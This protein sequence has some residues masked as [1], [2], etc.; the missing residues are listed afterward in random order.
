MYH[1][2]TCFNIY[3]WDFCLPTQ[4]IHQFLTHSFIHGS[5]ALCCALAAFSVS[6]SYTVSK[7]PW[8]GDQPVSRPLPT[9]TTAQTRNKR[10]HP[11]LEWDSNPSLECSSGRR[12]FVPKT[13]AF[14]SH[15]SYNTQRPLPHQAGRCR[16]HN[17]EF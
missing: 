16:G 6:Y 13:G 11:S 14:A 12:Q 2:H 8:T 17:L 7:T 3:L 1:K 10:R 5:T 15:C 4:C 9:H